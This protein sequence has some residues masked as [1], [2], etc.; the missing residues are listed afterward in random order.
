MSRRSSYG[1]N[2]GRGYQ[3]RSG[4]YQY[5][6]YKRKRRR[7]QITAA[8]AT[9]I[10]VIL[11]LIIAKFTISLIH[12]A[13]TIQTTSQPSAASGVSAESVPQHTD[14]SESSEESSAAEV[15]VQSTPGYYDNGIYI[16]NRQ[17]F[18]MFYGTNSS[19][20][21]YAEIISE[22]K[23]QL[24]SEVSVYN[25]VAPTNTAVTLPAKYQEGSDQRRNISTIYSSYTADVIPVDVFDA[26]A[27]HRGEYTYFRTDTNWTADGAYYAYEVFCKAAGIDCVPRD[28]L[29]RGEITGFEG[30]LI[31]ATESSEHPDGNKEL[32]DSTDTVVYYQPTIGHLCTLL[33]NGCD[34]EKQVPLIAT[35]AQGRYAYSAFLW[36]DN[37]YMKIKTTNKS[38]RKLCIIK[39]TYGNAFAPYTVT[40]FDEIFIVDPRYYE[41]SVIDFI[42]D[43]GYTDVL[44]INSVANANTDVRAYEIQ[45]I[46]NET[47]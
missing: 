10:T 16:W 43:N 15:S 32:L 18:E 23:R 35:F 9:V 30:T 5:G 42:K 36:G 1:Y 13:D 37:P 7:T 12:S 40:A 28:K 41:G 3:S 8:A 31:T 34:E 19:A 4:G 11:L 2:S 38:G 29:N 45:T 26:E 25:L 27:A 21:E 17:G 20:K 47:E 6:E 33:E 39:D 44:V 14:T 24:G 46:I 22:I